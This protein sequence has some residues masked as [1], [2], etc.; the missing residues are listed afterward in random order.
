MFYTMTDKKLRLKTVDKNLKNNIYNTHRTLNMH[1]VVFA[2]LTIIII[3]ILLYYINN[4]FYLKCI[5]CIF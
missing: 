2:I 3:I 1:F 4:I 5:N